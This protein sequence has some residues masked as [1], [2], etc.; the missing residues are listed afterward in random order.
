MKVLV[1]RVSQASVRVEG[2][3]VGAIGPGLL[4]LVGIAADDGEPEIARLA[5]KI[6]N[7]R[8]FDD[9][10]GRM[11]LSAIDLGAGA[12]GT[13][14][15]LVVS[16]FTLYADV[17]RGRRPS[18]VRAAPPERAAPLIERFATL[19][20]ASGF[21]VERGIFGA[22]MAVRLVND[23][24]VTILIDSDDLRRPGIVGDRV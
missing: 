14:G 6:V 4:L 12:P 20:G 13:V 7:L 9:P 10:D 3:I 15:M 11:N 16:Q 8:I 19:L 5:D 17:A 23:G 24:P 22:D 21:R 2:E 18:F 1:Q